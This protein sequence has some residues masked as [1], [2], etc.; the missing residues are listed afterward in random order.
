VIPINRTS[1]KGNLVAVAS[2]LVAAHLAVVESAKRTKRASPEPRNVVAVRR[3]MIQGIGRGH[4]AQ[5][6]AHCAKRPLA[7]NSCTQ[8][9][10]SRASVKVI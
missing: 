9:L 1:I 5:S 7:Q 8:A 2:A 4:A 10:P 6:L 3:V